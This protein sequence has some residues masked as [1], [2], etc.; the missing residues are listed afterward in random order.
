MQT[1]IIHTWYTKFYGWAML[2]VHADKDKQKTEHRLQSTYFLNREQDNKTS[3][4]QQGRQ[5]N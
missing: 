4:A 1:H 3:T 5:E 2:Y